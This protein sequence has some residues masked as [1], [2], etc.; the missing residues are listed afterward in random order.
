MREHWQSG[1]ED[2]MRTLKHRAWIAMPP[3]GQGVVVHDVHREDGL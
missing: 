3:P 1:Y 2:T